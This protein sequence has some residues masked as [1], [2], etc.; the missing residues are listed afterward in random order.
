MVPATLTKDWVAEATAA[1]VDRETAAS[2][3]EPPPRQ[4]LLPARTV[5]GAAR[6]RSVSVEA[7]CIERRAG[8]VYATLPAESRI[9]AL[10]EVPD[11]I[12]TVHVKL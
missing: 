2:E 7:V 5:N 4:L 11:G 10:N 8:P 9:S 12:S 6:L 3:V 1:V